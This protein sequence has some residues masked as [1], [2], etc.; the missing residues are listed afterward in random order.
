MQTLTLTHPGGARASY[1]LRPG[2][3]AAEALY[4]PLPDEP[5]AVYQGLDSVE[6]VEE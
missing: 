4:A 2:S 5:A 6:T 1:T 3:L